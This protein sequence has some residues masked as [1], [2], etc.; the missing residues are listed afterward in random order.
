MIQHSFG[1]K[2]GLFLTVIDNAHV[3]IRGPEQK[4]N[5]DRLPPKAALEALVPFTRDHRLTHPEFIPL[6][7]SATLHRTKHLEK[8]KVIKVCSRRFVSMVGGL[9]QRGVGAALGGSPRHRDRAEWWVNPIPSQG[10]AA[11]PSASPP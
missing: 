10:Q 2:E 11:R 1:S 7:T 6:V 8:S 9:L 3:D 4:M 5:L